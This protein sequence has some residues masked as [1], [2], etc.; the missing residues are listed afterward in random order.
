MRFLF[1]FFILFAQ[2][3]RAET[4]A[5]KT[6]VS[7]DTSTPYEE[8][9]ASALEIADP[10]FTERFYTH[11][12]TQARTLRPGK[13]AFETFPG[14]NVYTSFLA[15]SLS[16]G[17]FN[18]LQVGTA[19]AFYAGEDHVHNFNFKT[20]YIRRRYFQLGYGFSQFR[21]RLKNS[22]VT[23]LDGLIKKNINIDLNFIFVTTNY[24]NPGSRWSYGYNFSYG[25]AN[26]NS[27]VIDNALQTEFKRRTEWAADLSYKLSDIWLTTFGMGEQRED[28]FE[29]KSERLMGYGLSFTYLQPTVWFPRLTYGVHFAPAKGKSTFLLSFDI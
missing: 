19:P 24:R 16:V 2:I 5:P 23:E 20:N 7:T 14:G 17:V 25:V 26:S 1:L 9:N 4:V 10:Y 12:T 6:N 29:I 21:F 11:I 28:I 13:F 18:R 15:N 3:V 22:E 8:V 27:A